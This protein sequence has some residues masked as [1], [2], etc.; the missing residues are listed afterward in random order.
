[1]DSEFPIFVSVIL[2]AFNEDHYMDGILKDISRQN[3]PTEFLE[4]LVLEAGEYPE[5]RARTNLGEKSERLRYWRIPTLSRTAALNRLVKEAKGELVVR[6]DART[7]IELDYVERIVQL[8]QKENVANVGGVQIPVGESKEQKRIAKI[9]QHPLSFGGGKFRNLNYTGP[10]D[11]VYLGAFSRKMMFQEP[12]FDEKHP[13]ISEDSDVNFR[14]RQ[15]GGRVLVD[16]SIQ[17]QHFP[18]ESL[19]DFF[20]LCLNYGVG[21]G[22]FFVKHKRFSALRQLVLPSLFLFSLILFAFGFL[23][24]L[25]HLALLAVGSTYLGL[26]VTVSIK[27]ADIGGKGIIYLMTGFIG[28]HIFWT[29]GFIKSFQIYNHN[30]RF[31][32]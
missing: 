6:L 25:L 5:E 21:R 10:S 26:V 28:C 3:Y 2:T 13:K 8:S 9:M 19:R 24:P 17:V 14:I 12:W 29:L 31:N 20:K 22:L 4:I 1:M 27:L 7:H 16:S 23:F 15:S 11:S 30:L 32:L 18:R